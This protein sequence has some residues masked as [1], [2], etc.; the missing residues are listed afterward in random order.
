M[1]GFQVQFQ[2]FLENSIQQS[3]LNAVEIEQN[4][5]IDNQN[6]QESQNL[7]LQQQNINYENFKANLEWLRTI[8]LFIK[9]FQ[10]NYIEYEYLEMINKLL[11]QEQ[12]SSLA[13]VHILE[14]LNEICLNF[15]QYFNQTSQFLPTLENLLH[16]SVEKL[17]NN[18]NQSVYKEILIRILVIIFNISDDKYINPEK[19]GYLLQNL[20][21]LNKAINFCT[22][23]S[24]ETQKQIIS[25]KIMQNL[26]HGNQQQIIQLSEDLELEKKIQFGLKSAIG[27]VVLEASMMFA[28]YVSNQHE[29]IYQQIFVNDELIQIALNEVKKPISF[30]V[31]NNL[32]S[33]FK[34]LLI[35]LKSQKILNYFLQEIDF[36]EAILFNVLNS[37]TVIKV[38]ILEIVYVLLSKEQEFN[39]NFN[40]NQQDFDRNSENTEDSQIQKQEKLANN[41]KV[42][43]QRHNLD[44]ILIELQ[45]DPSQQL[46]ELSQQIIDEF[47]EHENQGY[48]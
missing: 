8:L 36:I 26:T 41:V 21:S 6:N 35:N 31:A 9:K 38:L 7:N 17:E 39:D 18:D 16:K 33:G 10:I 43:L 2:Q 19:I 34:V 20:P 4:K 30:D 12:I 29:K 5:N 25:Y 3:L 14:I 48:F 32:I 13:L 47:F 44:T 42:N 46:Y 24:Q 27:M 37:H 1:A 11:Q 40:C 22:I 23:K 45:K 15:N 28:N